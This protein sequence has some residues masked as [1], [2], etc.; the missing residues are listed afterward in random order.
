MVEHV[1]NLCDRRI[2][3]HLAHFR[4]RYLC[5]LLEV[6]YRLPVYFR[7]VAGFRELYRRAQFRHPLLLGFPCFGFALNDSARAVCG[8]LDNAAP[9]RWEFRQDVSLEP[10]HHARRP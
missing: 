1:G 9:L 7:V 2:V 10:T 3:P 4:K 5:G 6:L 8:N